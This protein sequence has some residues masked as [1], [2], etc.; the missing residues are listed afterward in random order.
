LEERI[1]RLIEERGPQTGAELREA[2]G[3]NGFCQWKTC[4]MSHRLAVKRVGRR[5]LRL[6]SRIEG[7]ARLSP[8]ILREFLTYSV[9]GLA[10][11]P[12]RLELRTDE[13][14]AHIS[15]VSAA[16]LRLAR[17]IV[18]EVGSRVSAGAGGEE[19]R[20]C[21]LLAGDIVYEMGHDAPR[22]ERS[23]GTMVRGSDLDLIVILDDQAPDGLTQQIDD[24]VY[25]QKYRQLINPSTREEID[26]VIKPLERLREQAAFDTF[27]H[28]V[29]CKILDE[30]VWL[31]GSKSLFEAAK[32]VLA[33]RGIPRKLMEM[34]DA[35]TQS[36]V[37]A[38]M[39]LLVGE[40]ECISGD[41]L[42]LF[43]PVEE[44]DEFD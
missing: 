37:Q 41:H 5:Y 23:T 11:D 44:S 38:E 16:K 27:K 2:L 43:Y 4:M 33:E 35:A 30:A 9:V 1:I 14:A 40:A 15:N 36:R 25:E 10:D 26:Y 12:A 28:I 20:F 42:Y 29:P 17:R 13:L 8:S 7:Y 21:V 39:D 32:A 34:E 19:E 3:D 18:T 22:P 24:A 31:Y 6:D